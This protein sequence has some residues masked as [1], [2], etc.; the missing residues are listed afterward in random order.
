MTVLGISAFYHDSAAALVVDGIVVAAIQEERL[1]RIK[2]D[3]SFPIL[4]C[5]W[6]LDFANLRIDDVDNIVFYEKPFLKF[7]RIIESSIYYAPYSFN[8]FQK[9]MPVWLGG[10]LNMRHLISKNLKNNSSLLL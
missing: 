10:K 7:E 9:A 4:A 6:C 5:R 3:N 8:F 1:S 2:H